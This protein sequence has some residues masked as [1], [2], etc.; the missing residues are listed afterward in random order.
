MGSDGAC[1]F[2][3]LDNLRKSDTAVMTKWFGEGSWMT[4]AMAELRFFYGLAI[5]QD[6]WRNSQPMRRWVCHRYVI[7]VDLYLFVPETHLCIGWE[8]RRVSWRNF[9]ITRAKMPWF[10]RNSGL[11]AI[12]RE[13]RQ[14]IWRSLYICL[15]MSGNWPES[16][17]LFAPKS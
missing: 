16:I 13:L 3:R 6:T 8:L 7:R 10:L 11:C 1:F 14:V 12:C 15:Q 17:V 9:R 2:P 4:A 5:R